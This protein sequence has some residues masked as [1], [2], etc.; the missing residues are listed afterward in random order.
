MDATFAKGRFREETLLRPSFLWENA[1]PLSPRPLAAP[2]A[3]RALLGGPASGSSLG[4]SWR[5]GRRWCG[6]VLLDPR[7]RREAVWG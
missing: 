1:A 7:R 6:E 5:T 2:L 4:T 3:R